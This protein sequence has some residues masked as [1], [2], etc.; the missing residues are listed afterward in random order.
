MKEKVR[1]RR[2][3]SYVAE[4]IAKEVDREI[5]FR[6]GANKSNI[7]EAALRERYNPMKEKPMKNLLKAANRLKVDIARQEKISEFTLVALTGFIRLWLCHNPSLSEDERKA[8]E[9][10]AALRIKKFMKIVMKDSSLEDLLSST[11]F[12]NEGI[13]GA[14]VGQV[15]EIQG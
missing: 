10:S 11:L 7:V 9:M 15:A 5:R 2:I 12:E 1:T 13:E 6:P 8:A 4:E 3:N 14:R